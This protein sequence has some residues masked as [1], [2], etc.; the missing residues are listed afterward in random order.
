MLRLI[1]ST[2]HL[3]GGPQMQDKP[4]W[5]LKSQKGRGANAFKSRFF[6]ARRRLLG[7]LKRSLEISAT[8][9]NGNEGQ[10]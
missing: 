6:R 1:A 5:V 4:L 2:P 10:G 7:G 3:F 8:A 9:F